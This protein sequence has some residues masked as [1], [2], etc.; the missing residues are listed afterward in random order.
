MTL[1]LTCLLSTPVE[2]MPN[3]ARDERN[4]DSQAWPLWG[5][6]EIKGRSVAE[7]ERSEDV[8]SI[9]GLGRLRRPPRNGP[10]RATL[11]RRRRLNS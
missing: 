3:G 6:A 2:L 4:P 5:D 9:E 10:S 1:V 8:R 7:S 11:S